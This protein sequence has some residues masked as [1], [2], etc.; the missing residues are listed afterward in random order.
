M[1]ASLA[2]TER[3]SLLTVDDEAPIASSQ[4]FILPADLCRRDLKS[5]EIGLAIGET[6]V[7]MLRER[8]F[9]SDSTLAEVESFVA[10][11]FL[12][13]IRKAEHEKKQN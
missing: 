8:R 13:R 12:R 6:S 2:I 4:R 3:G 5:V 9:R 1:F 11:E 7:I 10:E